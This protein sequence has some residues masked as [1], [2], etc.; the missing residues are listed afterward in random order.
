MHH[1]VDICFKLLRLKKWCTMT[2]RDIKTRRSVCF[3]TN[4]AHFVLQT[5]KIAALKTQNAF[6]F[7]HIE[8]V[9]N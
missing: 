9:D 8:A 5:I 2:T 7:F 4:R 6:L 3:S 1:A